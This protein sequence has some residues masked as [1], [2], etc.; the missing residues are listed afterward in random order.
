M[1]FGVGLA[2]GVLMG[3]YSYFRASR[4]RQRHVWIGWHLL[5]G[6]VVLGGLGLFIQTWVD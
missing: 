2:L 5:Y 3:F 4:K 6:V 1:I